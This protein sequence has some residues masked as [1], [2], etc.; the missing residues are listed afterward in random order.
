MTDAAKEGLSQIKWTSKGA[1][2]K[3][4]L[5]I[6]FLSLGLNVVYVMDR[7]LTVLQQSVEASASND[8][9]TSTRSSSMGTPSSDNQIFQFEPIKFIAVGGLYHT[10]STVSS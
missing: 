3:I 5:L 4:M 2:N 10:G 9:T 7:Q 1:L 8:K 6:L